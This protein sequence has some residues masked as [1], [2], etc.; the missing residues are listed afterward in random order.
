MWE[1]VTEIRVARLAAVKLRSATSEQDGLDR[2]SPNG[3]SW[4]LPCAH[5]DLRW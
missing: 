4:R 3:F 1:N 5:S 2:A